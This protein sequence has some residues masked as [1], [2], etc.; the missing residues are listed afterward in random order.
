MTDA[1]LQKW[2]AAR[3]APAQPRVAPFVPARPDPE[4][5]SYFSD[6]F[7]PEPI[8]VQED[9][10]DALIDIWR[11]QGLDALVALEPEIRRMARALRA[12][13]AD[14]GAVSSFVYAMY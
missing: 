4:C 2:F 3:L 7:E 9:M 6:V 13:K 11:R 10:I 1:D 8:V 5:A 14:A 12:P